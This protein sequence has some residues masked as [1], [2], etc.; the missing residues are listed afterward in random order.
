MRQLRPLVALALVASPAAAQLAT[1]LDS[2]TLAAFRWRQIGPAN[3]MG[4]VTD[5]EGVPGTKTFY[6]ASAA[7]GIWK[8]TNN[9]TTFTPVFERERVISMGDMAVAPSD[10]NV[11]YAGTGEEDSRNSISPG[12]GVYKSTDAGRTWRLVGLAV[13]P[14]NGDVV[15][16]IVEADT[17]A[18][19]RAN[20][21]TTRRAR[22]PSGLYRSSDGGRTW[23]RQ[24]SENNRPFYY[25]R[26]WVDPRNPDRIYQLAT[27]FSFSDDA[28]KTLRRGALGI[29]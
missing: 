2:T 25:S 29:H 23:T 14:R 5:I 27:N 26:I 24:N 28:G 15:Y 3:M 22:R 12:G 16:A 6:V 10:P 19:P 18:N 11:I 20:P 8:T 7:G 21:D 17:A 1:S 13:A 9:G 4:R